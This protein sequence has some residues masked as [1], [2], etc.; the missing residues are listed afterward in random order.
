MNILYLFLLSCSALL[1]TKDEHAFAHTLDAQLYAADGQYHRTAFPRADVG[2]DSSEDLFESLIVHDTG[3]KLQG[4][5]WMWNLTPGHVL[6]LRARPSQ[7]GE[8][9]LELYEAQVVVYYADVFR[10]PAVRRSIERSF[11]Q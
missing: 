7:V 8:A 3:Y 11:A 4:V 5:T 9:C 10:L 1:C 2:F 6:V